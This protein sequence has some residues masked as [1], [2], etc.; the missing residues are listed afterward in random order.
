MNFLIRSIDLTAT[1]RE[2]VRERE[3]TVEELSIGRAAE[4]DVHLPDL[5]VEQRHVRVVPGVSGQ[6][7]LE[8]VGSLGFTVNGR[9]T[10]DITIDPRE[11]AELGL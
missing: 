10:R 1:G 11:G 3:L 6:L 5:A 8:A 7:K 4:N 2:I 9:N